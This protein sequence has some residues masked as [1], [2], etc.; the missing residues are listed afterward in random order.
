MCSEHCRAKRSLSVCTHHQGSAGAAGPAQ[1]TCISIPGRIVQVML[2]RD[3]HHLS[4]CQ[5][6]AKRWRVIAQECQG[7]VLC[8]RKG[9]LGGS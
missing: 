7:L 5:Q 2:N 9:S 8:R 1:A 3:Q 6:F 4:D